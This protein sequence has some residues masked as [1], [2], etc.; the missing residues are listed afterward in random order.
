[1]SL[2]DVL[3]LGIKVAVSLLCGGVCYAAWLVAFLLIDLSNGAI[4]EAV[5]WLL[6]PVVTAAGFATGVLLHARLTKTSEAGF[7]R[8]A[9]W[10]LIG[11][12]AGAAAVYWFG[13]MLIVFSMLAAGTASVMLR[14]V[15][16]LRRAA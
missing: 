8:V 14:E 6:A 3:K 4:V 1:M 13:P 15:L 7:F 12:A 5:L 11:C 16:A 10:P 2:R 9:L